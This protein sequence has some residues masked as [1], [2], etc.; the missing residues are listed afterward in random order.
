MARSTYIVALGSNRWGRHGDPTTE[1][2]AA[3][4]LL[5]PVAASAIVTSA[6]IGPSLRRYANAVILIEADDAPPALLDRLK[7]IE[8]AF[9]RRNGQRWGTRVLDL[10][11]ILWSG[12]I[13]VS[14]DLAIPHPAFRARGFVLGPLAKLAPDWRDPVTGRT[15]R[16]L[17]HQLTI[18]RPLP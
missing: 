10:D 17:A 8:R 9:G 1:V 16:H 14:P 3:L 2:A 5:K 15:M 18:R 4:A 11:L 13:W 12:G 7:K 6:P